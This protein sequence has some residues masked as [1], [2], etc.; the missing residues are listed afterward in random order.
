MPPTLKIIGLLSIMH[1]EPFTREAY[2]KEYAKDEDLKGV[3]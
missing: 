1:M 2:K 3:H